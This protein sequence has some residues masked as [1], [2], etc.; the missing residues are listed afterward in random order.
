[1]IQ[2]LVSGDA[3]GFSFTTAPSDFYTVK[4]ALEQLGYRCKA[5]SDV[6]YLAVAKVSHFRPFF[7]VLLN[8]TPIEFRY[9]ARNSA[10]L[11][12]SL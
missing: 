9:Q 12:E 1:M 3:D 2:L 11:H 8:S 10:K 6:Q 4:A 7:R 5:E